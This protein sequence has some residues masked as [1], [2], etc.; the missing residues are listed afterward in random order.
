M[1]ETIEEM[2]CRMIKIALKR[3]SCFVI[4]ASKL[5]ITHR[6]L[7]S[8]RKKLGLEITEYGKPHNRNKKH[9]E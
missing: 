2:R 9:K 3:H 4:A 8:Y 7:Y 5:G 6:T 1:A